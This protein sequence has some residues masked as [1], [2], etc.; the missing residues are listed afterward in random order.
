MIIGLDQGGGHQSKQAS[1]R[2]PVRPTRS[3]SGKVLW[4]SD[5]GRSRMREEVRTSGAHSESP[6]L[7]Q[8]KQAVSPGREAAS[9]MS[10][11]PSACVGAQV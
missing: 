1:P 9:S 3:T 10:S 4:E 11:V 7:Q 8:N 6:R 5:S 2:T